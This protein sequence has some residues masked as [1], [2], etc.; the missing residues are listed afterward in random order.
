M[1]NSRLS[2]LS[3]RSRTALRIASCLLVATSA[4]GCVASKHY[5][6]ARFVAESE[7]TAHA[8]TRERLE[9]SMQRIHALEA[10]LSEKERNLAAGANLAEESK[11]ASTVATKEK[12]AAVQLVEQLRSELARTGDHLLLFAK[13]KRDLA[14]TLLVAEQR[15]GDIETAGKHLTELVAT[16]RDLALELQSELEKGSLELAARDG[17]VIVGIPSDKLFVANGDTLVMEAGPAL[18]ALGKVSARHPTLRVIVREPVPSTSSSVRLQRLS[19]ALRERGV[20]DSKLV[21]PA[22]RMEQPAPAP[23]VVT[24]AAPANGA[25]DNA[26]PAGAA[27]AAPAAA[28]PARYEIAFAP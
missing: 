15:M 5:D 17:Q 2:S 27:P 14:Q 24:T 22:A 16:T 19:D 9:A 8:R 20:V 26:D 10:E 25:Q 11:L 4:T 7:A 12:E 3:L 6:E 13:E 1:E 21:L 23:V 18:A 28:A